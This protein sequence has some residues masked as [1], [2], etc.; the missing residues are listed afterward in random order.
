MHVFN[1]RR[2]ALVAVAAGALVGLALLPATA[3][4]AAS[5]PAA[6]TTTTHQ[7]A[8]ATAQWQAAIA[9]TPEQ[10]SG[11]YQASY[12]ATQWHAVACVAAP[13]IALV[14]TAAHRSAAK[15][16]PVTVGDGTDYSAVVSGLITKATGTFTGVSSGISEKG[17]VDGSGS[18]VSNSFSLQL[19]SQFFTGSPACT[20]SS[21]PS[22]CQAWQQFVYTYNG[23]GTGDLFMQYWLIDYNATCPSGW[24]TYSTDCYTNSSASQVSEVTAAQ[25]A[26]VHLSGSAASGG[27]DAVSLSIGSGTA[28]T[29]TGKDTKIGLASYWNTTEWGVYGDGGGSA[30]DF[31]SS[32][33]LEAQTALT[34]SSSSA[35]SCVK[36]GFTG[37]TNNLTLAATPALGTQSSPTMGSKQTDGTAGTASCAVAA[38]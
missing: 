37:E 12:P 25:L 34:S 21:N 27:N 35:P 36:E 20:K 3:A 15:T 7:S 38:G 4:Q 6:T 31:G 33:T 23:G 26:T 8:A 2:P 28:T 24:Y 1:V 9:R 32:N 16:G 30:A 5:N 17:A 14:P 13:N 29:V 18:Q 19:N 10:G 22:G 11:C